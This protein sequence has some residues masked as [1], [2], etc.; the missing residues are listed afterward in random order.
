MSKILII[1]AVLLIIPSALFLVFQNHDLRKAAF[2]KSARIVIDV[3]QPG[4]VI[5][6][7]LWQN[8]SQGGEEK[9]DMI[10]P[11]VNEVKKL[12][13]QIIRIDHLF[14]YY[15]KING[16][17]YDF[18]V[19]DEVVKTILSTGAKP[20]FSLS[21][22]PQALSSDG[23]A[24]SPPKDWHQWKKLVSATV[25][26]YSGRNGFNLSGIY[27]EVW[28]EP[29]LFGN[30]HYGKNQGYLNLYYQTI[31]AIQSVTNVNPFK[32]GGPA[33]TGFYPN[34][35]T[36]LLKFCHQK[37]LRIDFISWHRYAKNLEEY[38]EDFEKLNKILTSYPEYF[39]L[40]RLITEFGPDPENSPWYD[41]KISAIHA[42][43][44]ATKLL[45]KV[46]RVFAFE[47]KDGPD[48]KGKR[49]WGRWG[50]LTHDSHGK[51]KKPRYYAYQFLNQL[52]GN[53]LPLEGEGSWVSA[54]AANEKGTIRVLIVNYDPQGRHYESPPIILKNIP[55]GQYLFSINYFLGRTSTIKE[56]VATNSI[57]KRVILPPNSAA[58][59]EWRK[60][61]P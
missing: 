41:S 11:V 10:A 19:L 12:S 20:M 51:D 39:R 42:I 26:R 57:V 6:S 8:F 27:Y 45:G 15:V 31:S 53:R 35:I 49:F 55:P 28:N 9:K 14:D 44:G 54:V 18:S 5:S 52:R 7:A 37:G 30:W 17:Q 25:S 40:E 58:L 43:A 3:S 50:L 34:W 29:D 36:E 4:S 46:H 22:M 23:K 47:L 13:P 32:V 24:I 2:G 48:P 59:L 16:D 60:I 33:T 1:L 61:S 21:Y 38:Q 56:E